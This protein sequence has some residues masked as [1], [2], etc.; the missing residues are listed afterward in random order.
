MSRR[1]ARVAAALITVIILG[2]TLVPTSGTPDRNLVSLELT[3]YR[4]LADAI[5]NVLLF[6][7]LG[8]ALAGCGLAARKAAGVGALLS[9]LVELVQLAIP[10]RYTSPWDLLFNAAGAALG[11][12]LVLHANAWA[13][14]LRARRALSVAALLAALLV[15]VGGGVLLRPAVPYGDLYGQW[16]AVFENMTA[17][18]GRVTNAEVGP[19]RIPSRRVRQYVRLRRLLVDS[20]DS[21]PIRVDFVAGEAPEGLAPIFGIFDERGQEVVL[22]GA[23]GRDIV[24]RYRMLARTA[25]LD[26]PDIR[27]EGALEDVPAETPVRLQIG[28]EANG[29][30][31]A[32]N[33]RAQCGLGFTLGDTWALLVHP[34]P[35]RLAGGLSILW[36]IALF[37]PA[38]FWMRESDALLFLAVGG[39]VLAI[40]PTLLMLLTTPVT[41]F[42]AAAAGLAFGHIAGRMARRTERPDT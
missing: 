6:I 24:Y 35:T 29:W 32:V 31:I 5:T 30:C 36:L 4:G 14:P 3:G 13:K 41:Q 28:H 17:Y 27:Y 25:R 39:G 37:T 15:L 18:S 34:L 33:E 11:A 26:E 42:L 38:G 7:P 16:T 9:L 2:A 12:V 20:A 40:A 19:V 8:V 22:V 21:A 10:G 1:R 23:T